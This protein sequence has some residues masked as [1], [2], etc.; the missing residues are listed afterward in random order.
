MAMPSRP[1][2]RSSKNTWY[3]TVNGKKVSLKVRGKSGAGEAFKEWGRLLAQ[4][5]NKQPVSAVPL[6][7]SFVS[8]FL[9]DSMERVQ[10][11]T[12]EFYRRFLE[13]FSAKY[14]HL[15]PPRTCGGR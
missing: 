2:F 14:G 11:I 15:A 6:V 5:P 3:A 4:V 1:W 8:A 13:P 7:S 9:A 12:M 10:P